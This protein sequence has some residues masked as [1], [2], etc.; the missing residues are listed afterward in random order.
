MSR[1]LPGSVHYKK[2]W[3]IW[4]LPAELEAIHVLQIR[5]A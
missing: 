4:G 2:A 5:E 3:W 1:T